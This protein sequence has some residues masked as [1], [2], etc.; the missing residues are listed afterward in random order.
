MTPEFSTHTDISIAQYGAPTELNSQDLPFLP[1]RSA[2]T[3]SE[4]SLRSINPST[5]ADFQIVLVERENFVLDQ[6]LARTTQLNLGKS[7]SATARIES[8]E[9]DIRKLLSHFRFETQHAFEL[10]SMELSSQ[11][12]IFANIK[13]IDKTRISVDFVLPIKNLPKYPLDGF[14][15][16]ATPSRCLCTLV[17]PGTEWAH[18]STLKEELKSCL[19]ISQRAKVIDKMNWLLPNSQIQQI[20]TGAIAITKANEWIHRRPW[21]NEGRLFV[22]MDPS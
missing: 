18:E 11:A 7:K 13:A 12:K 3:V 2:I 1:D 5:L 10:L 22:T 6:I 16:D 9:S 20:P 17:G 8:V 4:E 14:H 15:V 21:V 19:S